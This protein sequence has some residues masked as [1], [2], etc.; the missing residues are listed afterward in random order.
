[1]SFVRIATI[2]TLL[3]ATASSAMAQE[4]TFLPGS[5]PT[6]SSDMFGRQLSAIAGAKAT[7]VQWKRAVKAA[8]LINSNRCKDAYLLAAREQDPRLAKRIY[9]VCTTSPP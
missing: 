3:L 4:A 9:E 2:A 6:S 5:D 7:K 1:M 8:Y